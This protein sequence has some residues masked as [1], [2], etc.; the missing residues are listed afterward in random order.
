MHYL[1][2]TMEGRALYAKRTYTVEPVFEIITE[3]NKIPSILT[4]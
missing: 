3:D 4:A 1:Q 2:I